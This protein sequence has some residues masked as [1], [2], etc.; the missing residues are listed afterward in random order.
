MVITSPLHVLAF[1]RSHRSRVFA[2][3]LCFNI[4][5]SSWRQYFPSDKHSRNIAFSMI[6]VRESA[7]C[8][9]DGTQRICTPD[10]KCSLIN[11]ACNCVL[12]SWQ[13]GG[14][15]LLI[16]SY[17]DLQSV[18]IMELFSF[19]SCVKSSLTLSGGVFFSSVGSIGGIAAKASG[20]FSKVS[21]ACFHGMFTFLKP[22]PKQP[23]PRKDIYCPC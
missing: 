16:R 14:A 2:S 1:S 18:V 5:V 9:C 11:F 22:S 13:L 12:N 3:D 23:N 19:G 4:S 6:F 8:A 10:F 15:V 21:S 7:I 17:S 20:N